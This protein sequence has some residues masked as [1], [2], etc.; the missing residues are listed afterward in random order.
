MNIEQ[1]IEKEGYHL[2]EGKG[3]TAQFVPA[4]IIGNL[5]FVSGST[6]LKDGKPVIQGM[7]GGE[8][9]IE[10]AREAAKQ[11]AI[12][13]LGK[14]RAVLG[15]LDRVK[16]IIK[17]NGYIAAHPGFAGQSEVMNAASDLLVQIFGEKGRHARTAVG[18]SSLPG[19]A[20]L[21]IEM[22]VSFE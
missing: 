15:D 11:A 19:N 5:L 4:K 22:I 16:E 21:E 7:V 6:P 10:Q 20:P 18:V 8:V 12:C 13:E 2:P 14:I 3:S 17:V 1:K 9:G